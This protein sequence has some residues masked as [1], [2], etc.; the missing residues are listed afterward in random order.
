MIIGVIIIIIL[1]LLLVI[2]KILD[3][4]KSKDEMKKQTSNV[5]PKKPKIM[6]NGRQSGQEIILNDGQNGQ[7]IMPNDKKE[8]TKNFKMIWIS[9][10]R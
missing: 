7:E 10:K 9:I 5:E 8:T 3:Y 4:K 1:Y 6:P 2:F